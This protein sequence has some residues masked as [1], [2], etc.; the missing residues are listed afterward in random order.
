[1]FRYLTLSEREIQ[2][3]FIT[4]SHALKE[5]VVKF[6]NKAKIDEK[7]KRKNS[8]SL[9]LFNLSFY[10]FSKVQTNMKRRLEDFSLS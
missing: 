2:K 7:R 1:M 9:P 3:N 5:L 4:E 10:L 6:Q 8:L